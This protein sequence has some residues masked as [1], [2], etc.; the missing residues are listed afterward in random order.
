MDFYSIVERAKKTGKID[1][2]VNE[3][4]KAIELGVAK[5]VVY[6]SDVE[7]K[8][9]VAHLP[10]IAK[11]KGIPCIEV[12][13]KQKLGIAAGLGVKASAVAVIDAGEAKSDIA[14]IKPK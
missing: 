12:D 11:E 4:T 14:Q 1:K 9:I 10:K 5:L 6:A 8:E 7:P 13:S 3:V 2:G